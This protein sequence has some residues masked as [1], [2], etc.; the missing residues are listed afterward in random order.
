MPMCLELHLLLKWNDAKCLITTFRRDFRL[1]FV[2]VTFPTP[3]TAS[4]LIPSLTTPPFCP[5][6]MLI[7]SIHTSC[8][9]IT[10]EPFPKT[11]FDTVSESRQIIFYMTK[12]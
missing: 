11:S 6:K 8:V 9:Y 3:S 10:I 7:Q 2:S 4:S 12:L 5:S 1:S